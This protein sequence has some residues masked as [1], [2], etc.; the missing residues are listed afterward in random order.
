MEYR[1]VGKTGIFVSSLCFGTMSFGE[2]A[3]VET[4]KSMFKHCRNAGI[5]FFDMADVYNGGC[6][7]TL[8]PNWK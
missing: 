6:A 1:T 2:N 8:L 5:N 4:S 7:E 3:D